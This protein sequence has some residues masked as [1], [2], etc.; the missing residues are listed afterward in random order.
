MSSPTEEQKLA[1]NE[2]G[3]NIIVSAGAGS[4][5]TT[6]LSERGKRESEK[7]VYRSA[8]PVSAVG[9]VPCLL[10]KTEKSFH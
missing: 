4:G 8:G 5:K 3:K 6:V 1:I 7:L 2:I 9:G 10:E